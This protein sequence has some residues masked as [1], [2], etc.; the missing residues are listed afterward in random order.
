M[1][2]GEGSEAAAAGWTGDELAQLAFYAAGCGRRGAPV[3]ELGWGG[4]DVLRAVREPL[5][6][7]VPALPA[8][9]LALVATAY[10]R[11]SPDWGVPSFGWRLG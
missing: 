5:L 11:S 3:P 8:K 6:R 7:A 10:T 2:N 4:R 1:R 9:E